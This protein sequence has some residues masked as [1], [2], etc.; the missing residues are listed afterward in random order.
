MKQALLVAVL[1]IAVGMSYFLGYR[2]G[3]EKVEEIT[4]R[5]SSIDDAYP[6]MMA[7]Y[8]EVFRTLTWLESLEAT[9]SMSELSVLIDETKESGRGHV[10]LFFEYSDRVKVASGKRQEI[11]ILEDGVRKNSA[12]F[13]Q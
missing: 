13:E 9:S 4:H 10:A 3:I 5:V 6:K 8:Q 1:F 11:E 2:S 7:W 12:K